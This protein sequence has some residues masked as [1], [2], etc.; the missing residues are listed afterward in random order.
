MKQLD[1]NLS[2]MKMNYVF[3][4]DGFEEVEALTCVDVLR[5]AGM[6]VTTVSINPVLEVTAAHGVKV[7]ADSL[8]ADNDY[9]DAEWLVLPGG[10]PGAP[11]LLNHEGLRDV[12]LAQDEREG[13]IAAICA[14]PAI[15]LGTLG[16]LQGRDAVCYPGLEN[17]VEGV[18]WR[19]GFV[20]VDGHVV[21]GRGPAAATAFALAI[22]EQAMGAD[23][24]AEVAAGFLYTL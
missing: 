2:D 19:D 6:P 13:K 1:Y 10:I 20:A 11:N 16:I 9:R 24:A 7:L 17:T 8:F 18:N 5:R 12:L 15:V 23:K 4:A 3:L 14:S 22:V 21:T